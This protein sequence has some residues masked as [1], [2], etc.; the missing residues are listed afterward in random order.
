MISSV[1]R[2]SVTLIKN[3]ENSQLYVFKNRNALHISNMPIN[4]SSLSVKKLNVNHN[5]RSLEV[6]VTLKV[7]VFE[8]Y[9]S[10]KFS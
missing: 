2:I 9:S 7:N 10:F 4:W 5:I 8:N 6:F 1:P 3:Y